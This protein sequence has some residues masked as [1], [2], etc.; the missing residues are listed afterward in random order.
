MLVS[1]KQ[2]ADYKIKIRK[3]GL[4]SVSKSAKGARQRGSILIGLI[5]TM[6]IMAALG[7]GMVYLTSTS[8]FQELFANNNARAYYAAESGVRYTNAQIRPALATGND[9]IYQ[10]MKGNV[11]D[12]TYTMAN[13]DTFE[14]SI[15]NEDTDTYTDSMMITYDSI[16]TVGSGFLQAKRKITYTIMPANQGS[17]PPTPPGPV[18][19]FTDEDVSTFEVPKNELD[20]YYSPV[21]MNEVDIKDN[22][23][24][25][26]DRALNLK[27]DDYT[28]GLRWYSDLSFAQLDEIRHNNSDLLSY[29]VQ[30]QIKDI[31]VDA[32]NASPWSIVGISFRVDDR[33]DATTT[34]D[35]DNMY[36]ISFIKLIK[37]ATPPTAGAKPAW[38]TNYFYNTN[39][40][41]TAWDI[42]ST[43]TNAG[44]WFV[45]LWKRVFSGTTPTFTP[46]AYHKITSA[47]PVWKDGDANSCT[48]IDYWAT[49]MVYIKEKNNGTNEI[50]GYLS[51]PPTYARLI[52]DE[53]S[54]AL[55]PGVDWAHDYQTGEPVP[56]KVP[57]KFKPV[58]WTLTAE[59]IASGTQKQATHFTDITE[60]IDIITDNSLTT[61]NYNNSLIRNDPP[62]A[63]KAR[64]IGLHIFN[65]STS[66]QNIYYDN[67]FIDLSPSIGPD[68]G[69]FVDPEPVYEGY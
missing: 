16:G 59:G 41:N 17:N 47:D 33:N 69:D 58:T 10:I 18:N 61:A 6:V 21:D 36:S 23:K 49:I 50:T 45:V 52:V 19:V 48:K 3:D 13:G 42:F 35:I 40:T 44:R 26:N 65:Q 28:M 30:V 60:D 67:F 31:D 43:G 11:E 4:S 29:G 56:A 64:E 2:K 51:Q 63:I 66:A 57:S 38:Y 53:I 34:D 7:A 5:I 20:L 54:G 32:N 46:L 14:I 39:Y 25:D 12:N 22:P 62:V 9:S 15:F 8:T 27:A 24:V 68:G 1:E 55:V 37:P